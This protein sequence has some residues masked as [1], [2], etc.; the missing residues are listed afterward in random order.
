MMV[1]VCYDVADRRRLRAV[2]SLLEA[3]GYRVQRSVFECDL[4]DR[5]LD[6]LVFGLRGIVDRRHDRVHLFRM[7]LACRPSERGKRQSGTVL[8]DDSMIVI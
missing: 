7:C 3:S 4:N 8:D 2:A 5:Q 6:A 1:L